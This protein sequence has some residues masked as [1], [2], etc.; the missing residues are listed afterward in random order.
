[1]GKAQGHFTEHDTIDVLHYDICLDLGHHQP[2]H[3]QG[4]CEVTL[5][6][7]QP[8]TVVSLGLMAATIDSVEVDR[9]RIGDAAYGYDQSQLRIPVGNATVGD[10]LRL[11]VHYGSSG[12]VGYDGGFWCNE[13]LFY[14]LGEDRHVRPFSMGRSWFPCSDSVY[15]RATYSFHITVPS[16][17][18]AVCS[19]EQT[20]VV[21]NADSSRTFHFELHH[22]ISTYQA[23]INAAPYR[24]YHFDA[25]GAY[26]N[27][28]VQVACLNKDSITI[29]HYFSS[30]NQ[31]LQLY[32]RLFGPYNWG[33][34]RFSEGGY[35]AGMEHVNNICASFD[36]YDIT[37][38]I[39]HEFAHQWFG[40]QVTCARLSDMWFN[41]GGATFAD[42][43]A[44]IAHGDLLGPLWYKQMAIVE[45]PIDE[46]GYHPLCG[47][48]NQYSFMNTTYYKGAMVFHQ[49]RRLLGDSTFFSMIQ[50]LLQRN[51]YTN[52]DSYQLRDSMSAYCGQDLTDFFNFHIFGT[53]FSSY[54]V[55]SLRTTDGSTH[56]WLSQRLWHA[57][58]YCHQAN[59]PVTFFSAQGD[60]T[61]R[62]VH[63]TGRY[64]EGEFR[65]PFTPVFALVDYYQL[66]ANANISYRLPITSTQRIT[67]S[68]VQMTILPE[69]INDTV[70]MFVGLQ[71]GYPDEEL[72]PGLK[73]WDNRRWYV[74]GDYNNNFKA[75]TGF[76][77]GDS[78]PV[79][80]AE[81]YL[82]SSTT[83]SLR[84][85]YRKDASH[86][87]KMRKT[88]TV[89]HY[90]SPYGGR[91]N[92]MQIIGTPL[93]GEYIM[94]V[95]DTALLDIEAYEE[96]D[97]MVREPRLSVSPN[98]A[99][100][101][102]EVA[103]NA[104]KVP[105]GEHRLTVMDA[106]GKRVIEL[107]PDS[108]TTSIQTKTWPSGIYF[109]TLTNPY[110][111][112]TKKIIIQ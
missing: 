51:A 100:N 44:Q 103:F 24:V 60:T 111:S 66:S 61:S 23:G 87:W 50:T 20:N 62:I 94:A 28:P 9:V 96:P 1:M 3:I 25:E 93:K 59:V 10:T 17:W 36:Y 16:G 7:L 108:P 77:F 47:M 53:G 75:K 2:R 76:C 95:V 74:N 69:N 97:L 73:R 107:R 48:P 91:V 105:A 8:S 14:N 70:N 37:Y 65:L 88:A 19:G 43:L 63:S 92:F 29:A 99:S 57:A 54:G 34:I 38:L 86:P 64:S 13:G 33:D 30:F 84:L 41:E 56:I 35:N 22:P 110:G 18:T 102:V 6:M 32:E 45:T 67:W 11:K 83:D 15:D 82:G 40:N 58:D 21:I 4:W 112:T 81:F 104:D 98:P 78:G 12:W 5:R 80:D 89:E 27:Y 72:R 106:T 26:G 79:Y 90:S 101:F 31:T 109:V 39:D 42:Q 85:F 55:D 49:L 46:E 71:Y 52:M 68:N